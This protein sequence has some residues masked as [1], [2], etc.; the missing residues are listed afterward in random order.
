MML[1]PAATKSKTG[2][3]SDSCRKILIG[4]AKSNKLRNFTNS[5]PSNSLKSVPYLLKSIRVGVSNKVTFSMI[6]LHN[7]VQLPL[8]IVAGCSVIGVLILFRF[9]KLSF[10]PAMAIALLPT[11]IPREYLIVYSLQVAT[12]AFLFMVLS[13]FYTDWG[14]KSSSD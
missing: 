5:T 13:R 3:Y 14:T 2:E 12:G 1:K 11:I 9:L 7:M 10:P 8:V 4:I 6:V